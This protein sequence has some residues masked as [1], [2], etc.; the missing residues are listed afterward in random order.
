MALCQA[1]YVAVVAGVILASFLSISIAEET[2]PAVRV[3][4]DIAKSCYSARAGF[5]SLWMSSGDEL[6]RV[7]FRDNSVRRVPVKGLQAWHSSVTVGEGAVWLG[8]ARATIYKVD[9]QTEQV[10]KE[11]RVDLD[12]SLTAF[13]NLAAGEGSVWVTVGNRKLGRYS[14]ASGAE[15][16]TISLPSNSQRVLVAFGFVWVSGTGNDELYRIDP[17][18]NQIAATIELRS[19]PRALAAGDGAIWVFNEGDGTVQRIDV[20]AGEQI[21]TVET[22]TVGLA[23]MTVGGGFIW[24]GTASREL[25]QI[26][27]RSNSVRGK[28]K[29]AS[30]DYMAIGYGDASLWMCGSAVYRITPPG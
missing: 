18:T 21:A 8:D 29:P 10:I 5:G 19:R 26:D 11:I 20:K 7:D 14:A 22:G 23:D 28:F 3:E 25:I 27:P 17:A 6:D 24:V 2:T 15:E 1:R 12:Q 4:A 30:G 16:A 13:W 9:P